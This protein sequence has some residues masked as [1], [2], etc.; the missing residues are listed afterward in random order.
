MAQVVLGDVLQPRQFHDSVILC[1][2]QSAASVAIFLF[3]SDLIK[4][5]KWLQSSLFSG[6]GGKNWCCSLFNYIKYHIVSSGTWQY[7]WLSCLCFR[8]DCWRLLWEF[9]H[10]QCSDLEECKPDVAGT[11]HSATACNAPAAHMTLKEADIS[12]TDIRWQ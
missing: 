4:R 11:V 7:L 12:F 5:W 8:T 9:L 1:N 10:S 2:T 6:L 3:S